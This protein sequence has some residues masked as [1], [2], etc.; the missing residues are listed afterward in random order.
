MKQ[1]DLNPI[2]LALGITGALA[3]SSAVAADNPFSLTELSSDQ[4]YA[5]SHGEEGN[6]GEGKCG[7]GRCGEG[8]CGEDAKDGAAEGEAAEG[9]AAEGEAA[10]GEAAEGE[11]Q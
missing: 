1:K 8:K 3:C 2:A 5:G 7:E 11:S 10:E 9:E 4:V 6:C